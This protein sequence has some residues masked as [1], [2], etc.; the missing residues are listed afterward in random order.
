M[1]E[2]ISIIVPAYNAVSYIDHLFTCLLGQ[3]Y[4]N[5][6]IILVND[7]STDDTLDK[8]LQY[9]QADSRVRIISQQNAGVSAARNRGME[10]AGGTYICF[11]DVDDVV[12][13]DFIEVLYKNAIRDKC[14]VVCCGCIQTTG[15]YSLEESGTYPTV[16]RDRL[17]TESRDVFI[18]YCKND[19][20]YGCVVWAKIIKRS[21]AARFRFEKLKYGEDTLF[22]Q[23]VLANAARIKLIDYRGY[24]YIRWDQSATQKIS[25]I[26]AAYISDHYVVK[27]HLLELSLQ[28]GDMQIIKQA[29]HMCAKQFVNL[30]RAYLLY[31]FDKYWEMVKSQ[32]PEA[33]KRMN[34]VSIERKFKA[35][36]SACYAFPRIYYYIFGWAY[37][38]KHI[39]QANRMNH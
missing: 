6:E 39:S 10:E 18:D 15:S 4:S 27:T 3:T 21:L 7:G 28:T 17:I 25:P 1:N 35:E 13:Q 34:T 32:A 29:E 19:E 22:M 36:I 24:Y 31:D 5:L 11:I 12:E 14:D 26:E 23:D 38:R 30:L 20:Q 8:C 9:A 37:R 33:K 16:K 2:L